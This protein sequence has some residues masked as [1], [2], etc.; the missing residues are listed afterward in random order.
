[1]EGAERA[2]SAAPSPGAPSDPASGS[3]QSPAATAASPPLS[4]TVALCAPPDGGRPWAETGRVTDGGDTYV[5][6]EH[7]DAGRSVDP[8]YGLVRLAE[9][10]CEHQTVNYDDL[11][12]N[13]T[14][15][16]PGGRAWE[17]LV[18]QNFAWHAVQSGSAAAYAD[19]VRA[20]HGG[21]LVECSPGEARGSCVPT[22][23]ARPFAQAGIEV[24]VPRY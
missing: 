13:S 4:E 16:R 6:L 21:E 8:E 19:A 20:A 7:V 15:R 23:R 18:D 3:S 17:D 2:A 1:M 10:G 14:M 24:G 9:G 5:M 12:A 22:W 11:G